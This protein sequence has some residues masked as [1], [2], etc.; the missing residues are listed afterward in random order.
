MCYGNE[1]CGDVNNFRIKHNLSEFSR[2]IFG[3]E[4]FISARIIYQKKIFK[5][6]LERHTKCFWKCK[7]GR[8]RAAQYLMNKNTLRGNNKNWWTNIFHHWT[9]QWSQEFRGPP[10]DLPNSFSSIMAMIFQSLALIFSARN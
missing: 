1:C 10:L 8:E 6:F 9:P 5:T 4:L 2:Q 7:N 3:T